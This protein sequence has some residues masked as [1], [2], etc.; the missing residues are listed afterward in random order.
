MPLTLL[1]LNLLQ[2]QALNAGAARV[3]ALPVA[4]GALPCVIL[5]SATRALQEGKPPLWFSPFVFVED[6]AEQVVGSGSF[7]GY[8]VSGRVELGYGVAD[9]HQDRGIATDAVGQLLRIAFAE[10]DVAEVYAESSTSNQ[11]SRR[12]LEKTGFRHLGQRETVDDGRV[13]QWLVSR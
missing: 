10:P 1:A 2:L 8:P 3:D 13:D 7:K 12:V 9:Q 4:S 11:A 5:A 6:V